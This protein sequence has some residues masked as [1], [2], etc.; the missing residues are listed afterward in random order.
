MDTLPKD[1][2]E[3]ILSYLPYENR[4]SLSLVSKTIYLNIVRYNDLAIFIKKNYI[5][6]YQFMSGLNQDDKFKE[7]EYTCITINRYK[8]ILDFKLEDNKM[9][10]QLKLVRSFSYK[11][12]TDVVETN[13][14]NILNEIKHYNIEKDEHNVFYK[15]D[16]PLYSPYPI[17]KLLFQQNAYI[18]QIEGDFINEDEVD[19][20]MYYLFS[21]NI[22]HIRILLNFI[23]DNLNFDIPKLNKDL[24]E[25]LKNVIVKD[26]IN[27][28][29]YT[30]SNYKQFLSK[31]NLD[32]SVYYNKIYER[33]LVNK[34]YIIDYNLNNSCDK[35]DPVVKFF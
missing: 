4:I 30:F 21:F 15:F 27:I 12:V 22:E 18:C 19:T 32:F 29:D 33:G 8:Y 28:Y 23:Q 26:K 31:Y 24:M 14:N 11:N 17:L 25:I 35:D 7:L 16:L 13:I 34:Y 20:E 9:C 3:E 1:I 6:M 10:L 2:Y 5:Y